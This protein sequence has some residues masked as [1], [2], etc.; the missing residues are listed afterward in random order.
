MFQR[1]IR[2]PATMMVVEFVLVVLVAG[3]VSV[4]AHAL[5]L[6]AGLPRFL[7]AA[8]VA[9]AVVG[10][11]K[12]LQSGYER[13]P[14]GE[15]PFLCALRE[16]GAGLGLGAA[17]FAA[18]A[19]LVALLGGLRVAGV[20]GLGDLWGMLAMALTSSVV[21]ETLFRGILF[22]HIERMA[23]TWAA[24]ALTSAFFGAAHLANPGATWFAAVA[25]CVEA[26]VLLGAA[27]MLSR[28]LWLAVGIH[29]GWN[30]TQGWVFSAPVSGGKTPEGLLITLRQGPEWLTGGAFGLEASAVAMVVASIAGVLLLVWAVRLRGTV[31]PLWQRA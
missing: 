10:T 20:N 29:A 28:R 24:L 5:H 13:R 17:V 8:A 15:F 18:M 7:G 2:F 27:Y 6:P 14:D 26:G 31:G 16:W 23:G 3:G 12:L 1:F 4:L 19:G 30:F 21:E 9:L 11:W 22:R 25:I